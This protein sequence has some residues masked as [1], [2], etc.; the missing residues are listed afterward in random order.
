MVDAGEEG[1]AADSERMLLLLLLIEGGLWRAQPVMFTGGLLG[2]RADV[3]VCARTE[4]ARVTLTGV[5]GGKISGGASYGPGHHVVL[6]GD[7]ASR[8]R[9]FRVTLL[10]VAPSDSW[11]R[12]E[13]IVRLPLVPTSCKVTLWRSLKRRHERPR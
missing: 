7:L 1:S 10:R 12:L 2:V 5:P 3:W 11:D 8:L 13:I 9:R 4:R 6:D